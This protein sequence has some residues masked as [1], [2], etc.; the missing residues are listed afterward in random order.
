MYKIFIDIKQLTASKQL[1]NI[2]VFSNLCRE[3]KINIFL[4]HH[5]QR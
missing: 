4:L 5:E 2:N 3:V 1:Y